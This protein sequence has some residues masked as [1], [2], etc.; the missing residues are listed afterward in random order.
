MQLDTA[1]EQRKREIDNISNDINKE[2]DQGEVNSQNLRQ[3]KLEL[4]NTQLEKARAA[5]ALRK[6]QT[7]GQCYNQIAT[8]K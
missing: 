2:K 4:L 5:F 6:C 1:I 3:R 8:S 7:L